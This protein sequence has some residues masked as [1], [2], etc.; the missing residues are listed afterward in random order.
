MEIKYLFNY[1]LKY[2]IFL[3][4]GIIIFILLNQNENFNIGNQ[5]LT[6]LQQIENIRVV[7]YPPEAESCRQLLMDRGGACAL[8]QLLKL[9]AI[10]EEVITRE[11]LDIIVDKYKTST[12]HR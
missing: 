12:S 3:T 10:Q 6:D 2:I 9:Y 4:I 8:F 7:A 5:F 1:M 11:E